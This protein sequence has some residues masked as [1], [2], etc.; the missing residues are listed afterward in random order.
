MLAQLSINNIAVI[1]HADIEFFEGL[2]VLTGETGAGKSVIIGA[3]QMILGEKADKNIIRTGEE[4]ASVSAI[5]YPDKNTWKALNELGIEKTEDDSLLIFR[6][7][8][9]SGRGVCKINGVL[10]QISLI[11]E[12]ANLLVNIHGQQDTSLL[13][14]EKKQLE[15]IDSRQNEEFS[16]VMAE[17]T[18]LFDRLK[19]TEKN[20]RELSESEEK[21]KYEKELL[22]FQIN[23]I[24]ML[25]LKENE[26]EQ[27]EEKIT[28]LKNSEVISR[29]LKEIHALLS[30]GEFNATDLL[31]S[32]SGQMQYL[33]SISA[34]FEGLSEQLDDV[35]YRLEDVAA[36]ISSQ[37]YEADADPQE[38]EALSD[39]LYA[40]KTMC[41]KYKCKPDELAVFPQE[42]RLRLE[43]L[44]GSGEK[45][46]AL[47]KEK[48][49]IS[50]R[51]SKTA[52]KLSEM[53]KKTALD[54][55]KEI[56]AELLDLNMP[57]VRFK[58]QI[59][60]TETIT[61]TGKDRVEFMISPNAGESLKPMA[62]VASGGE[63]SRIM[64]GVKSFTS[65]FEEEKTY[66]FD[67]I[68]TGISGVTA[69]KV[70]EKL[71]K[72]S[73]KDQTIVITHSAHIAAKS[74]NHFLIKKTMTDTETKTKVVLLDKEG[75]IAEIARIN[76]GAAPSETAIAQA[77]EMLAE[78]NKK[79]DNRFEI[80]I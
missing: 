47:I 57:K 33:K 75:R 41:N 69:Q 74:D 64:L 45:L 2:N 52:E 36:E 46:N 49:D 48:A 30:A 39:R 14:S 43:T 12:A 25:G 79:V 11:K 76:A 24:E 60:E 38:L 27:L 78:K 65:A 16:A 6:E 9:A 5:F 71:K 18:E 17:H 21:R 13:Y 26:A 4:K 80:V 77:G 37:M 67:E 3:I 72:I 29:T 19:E 15:L 54:F 51:L 70:A 55:E 50:E 56:V 61:R 58:V 7:V 73:R 32:A 44:I 53:R 28:E 8:S 10:C 40:I 63:M 68:D 34:R 1:K 22:E 42:A 62:K 31:C 35:T 20:I 23:E 59:S 66:I